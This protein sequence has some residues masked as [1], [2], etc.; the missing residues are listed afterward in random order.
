MVVTVALL[1][2]ALVF[3]PISSVWIGPDGPTLSDESAQ[4]IVRRL[5][6]EAYRAHEAPDEETTYDA[7]AEVVSGPLLREAYLS[8]KQVFDS[9]QVGR[10]RIRSVTIN[11]VTKLSYTDDASCRM[12]CVWTVD[13][14]VIHWGHTHLRSNQYDGELIIKPIDGKW[15][16]TGLKIIDEKQLLAPI[17]AAL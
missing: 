14:A 4:R 13:V 6:D 11:T 8:M 9:D 5:L 12:R 10:A 16:L 15:M 17:D 7:L 2:S 1:I 3:W